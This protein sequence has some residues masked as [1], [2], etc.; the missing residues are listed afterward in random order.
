MTGK[1]NK[2]PLWKGSSTERWQEYRNSLTA[3]FYANSE[4]LTQAQ[5]INTIAEMFKGVGETAAADSLF[6]YSQVGATID[7]LQIDR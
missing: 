5:T 6:G 4:F 1:A 2:V 3:W 7:L